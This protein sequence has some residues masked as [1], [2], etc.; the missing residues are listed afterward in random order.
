[1]E[2]LMMSRTF[3]W[4]LRYE[5][6]DVDVCFCHHHVLF[7]TLPTD[8][9]QVY[10]HGR[11]VCFSDIVPRVVCVYNKF[12]F[13]RNSMS[14]LSNYYSTYSSH[15]ATV[16]NKYVLLYNK[17]L[18]TIQFPPKLEPD[19]GITNPLV[20]QSIFCAA[21]NASSSPEPTLLT[22]M[23]SFSLSLISQL[24]GD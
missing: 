5:E 23:W 19:S 4:H 13:L 9:Y 3:A 2:M 11:D 17:H 15:R 21:A 12:I 18:A 10:H 14:Y 22:S 7:F 24:M 6:E 20:L 1:M 8:S 16:A